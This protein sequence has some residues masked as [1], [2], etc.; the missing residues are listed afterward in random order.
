MRVPKRKS[1]EFRKYNRPDS[2]PVFVTQEGLERLQSQLARLEKELPDLIAEVQRTG[3]FGDFSENAE[4]QAAKYLLRRT[5]GRIA[6]LKDR[7]NRIEIITARGKHSDTVQIGSTVV[8]ESKGKQFI[9][10]ILGSYESDPAKGR[11]SHKSPLGEALLHHRAGDHIIIDTPK[12]VIG[13][14]I[15]KIQ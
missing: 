12:G 5:H 4:Y 9:Y 2:T 7:L 14:Q 1:E 6:S 13:Y 15:L 3:A 11:I 10:Q 8:L